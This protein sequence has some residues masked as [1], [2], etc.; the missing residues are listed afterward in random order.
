MDEWVECPIKERGLIMKNELLGNLATKL[1][2]TQRLQDAYDLIET[3]PANQFSDGSRET[4]LAVMA[5]EL[6]FQAEKVEEIGDEIQAK[7]AKKTH[8][9]ES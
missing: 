5:D 6:K 8:D 2:V 9:L 1:V 3:I 7:I 4:I